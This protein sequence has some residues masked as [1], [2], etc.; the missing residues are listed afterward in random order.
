MTFGDSVAIRGG[1]DDVPLLGCG[2]GCAGSMKKVYEHS[3]NHI[4]NLFD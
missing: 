4:I 2:F 3:T 1:V